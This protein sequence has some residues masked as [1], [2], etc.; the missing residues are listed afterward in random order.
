ME[1]HIA[2]LQATVATV[3]HQERPDYLD[4]LAVLR[5]TSFTLDHLFQSLL[6]EHG[7]GPAARASPALLLGSIHPALAL[8]LLAG[9]PAVLTSVWRPGVERAVEESVAVPRSPGPPP[10]PRRHDAGPAKEVR[11]TGIGAVAAARRRRGPGALR[12]PIA[13]ARWRSALWSSLAWAVFGLAYVLG[14]AWV[15]RGLDRSVGDIV[16][17]VVAGQRL[18][19]YIAQSVTELGFLRGVW[20]DSSLRLTWLEDYAAALDGAG[21]GRAARPDRRR[22]SASS[23]CRSGTRAPTGWRWTTSTSTSR[24]ARSSRSSARTAPASRRSSSCSAGMYRPTAGRITVDGVDIATM[25]ERGVARPSGRRVPG[26]LPLRAR[27]PPQRRRRRR[28][29]PRR[30]AGGRRR[31]R[32]GRGRR[33]GRRLPAG[34]DTQLGPTWDDG[35]EV[36]FGQWQKVALARGFMRDEPLVLVLDEPTAALDAE[37]EHALFERYAERRPRRRRNGRITVLVS[38]RFSTVRMADLIVVLDGARVV[39][40][41]RHEELIAKGGQYAELFDIQAG[42]Y[43]VSCATPSRR[44]LGHGRCR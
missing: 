4:R 3:E 31:R 16:L 32:P 17:V 38:H 9:A 18:S 37:T 13:A 7:A 28:A 2:R 23:T 21:H 30:R 11:V 20:L 40:V 1:S 44:R 10:L 33:R 5:D 36:S 22:A 8:L 26:L 43:R 25:Y 19:A 34:L 24:R 39:E 12:A 14:I 27:R 41:G 15:A 35:V 42:A 29:A 6:S